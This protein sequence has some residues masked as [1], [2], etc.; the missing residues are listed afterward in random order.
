MK[1]FV[2]HQSTEIVFG[3]GRVEEAGEHV[4]K[5]GKRCLLVTTPDAPLQDLYARVKKILSRAG[6]DVV[7]FD[8]VI[9]NPTT[10]TSA[11]GAKMAVEHRADV[12]L[13][14]G[15]GS[16]MDAAK[17]IAVEATHAGSAWDYL[18]YKEPAPDPLKVLPVISISTT[19]GTGSQVTQVSVITNTAERDKSALYNPVIFPKVAIV[20]PE[21]M[22]SMPDGVTAPT[23]FDVFCHAFESL[24]N[25][26][27]GAYVALMAKEAIRLVIEYLPKVLQDGKDIEAREKM[28]WA[29]TLAGLSIA[30]AGVTLPHG[31]GMAV[32]G[33]YP[34]VAH[35]EALAI[36]YPACTR[37]TATYAVEP[38]ALL[39]R[40]LN[41]A[42]KDI[43]DVEAAERS[44]E[45]IVSF[46]QSVGLFKGLR[47]IN[48][49][50]DEI[51]KLA[52]QS[53]VLPDYKAHPR[54]ATY[55]EMVE[56]VKE[57]YYQ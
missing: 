40:S 8:G 42:L 1:H 21:L 36:L 5:Y 13:G 3:S 54:V 43:P 45:E 14:L 55:E 7:H 37:F 32:G 48:M 4:L 2:Y 25:P 29:D 56:L 46:L 15:G 22:L 30:S 10:E 24:L 39:A 57:A 9:P 41:P 20:D 34:N 19:S 51:E 26:A 31:M 28:A 38:H 17:A 52:K 16:S 6:V 53:M 12:I 11:S 23:G 49:P 50:E 27:T 18:F 44:Y 47:D 35:G 33:L